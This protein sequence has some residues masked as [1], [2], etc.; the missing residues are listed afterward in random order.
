MKPPLKVP[1]EFV[2]AA[3]PFAAPPEPLMAPPEP[4][5]APP[6]PP[7][8]SSGQVQQPHG[9]PQGLLLQS[10]VSEA[11]GVNP[12]A[13]T[14]ATQPPPAQTT[15]EPPVP[16]TPPVSAVPPLPADPDVPPVFLP[17]D[18]AEPELPAVLPLE[19]PAPLEPAAPPVARLASPP[20]EASEAGTQT[21]QL[22]GGW[23]TT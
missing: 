5:L 15:V 23:L 4:M 14:R 2:T 17:P 6:L 16:E 19:P 20:A 3:P 10:Q 13:Q 1:P 21:P 22:Q 8:W 18:P 11:C 12:S 7:D 9:Q